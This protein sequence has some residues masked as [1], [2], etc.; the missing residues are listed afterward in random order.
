MP[1]LATLS[2]KIEMNDI[3][4]SEDGLE[5]QRVGNSSTSLS[6]WTRR[7]SFGVAVMEESVYL[8]GG[9]IDKPLPKYYNDIWMSKDGGCEIW[10]QVTPISKSFFDPLSDF[11]L[12]TFGGMLWII[13]G[14]KANGHS[15]EIWSGTPSGTGWIKMDVKGSAVWGER[16]QHSAVTCNGNLFVLGGK[17]V[18]SPTTQEYLYTLDPFSNQK[19]AD[20]WT[21]YVS[22]RSCDLFESNNF[23][24]ACYCHNVTN[25]VN[26]TLVSSEIDI[27]LWV[28][29]L[30]VVLFVIGIATVFYLYRR[31]DKKQ[32]KIKLAKIKKLGG[33][34]GMD[35]TKNLDTFLAKRVDNAKTPCK[36]FGYG[37]EREGK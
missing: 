25:L 3:Y 7:S 17:K 36:Y 34:A 15:N 21:A 5:W 2:N 31:W 24:S 1:P 27:P 12:L 14:K 6:R 26:T 30:V 16:M 10:N 20:V 22:E 8:I 23:R 28:V 4:A 13:G 19:G 35:I 29:I 37:G 9:Y 33:K 18:T 32:K 11:K